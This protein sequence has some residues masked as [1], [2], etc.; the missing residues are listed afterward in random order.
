MQI[1]QQFQHQ[2]YAVFPQLLETQQ[3]NELVEICDRIKLQ[4]FHNKYGQAYKPRKKNISFFGDA[5]YFQL[6]SIES[7]CLAKIATDNRVLTILQRISKYKLLLND[8]EYFFNPS[9]ASW[10]GEWH[11][12]GQ[13]VADSDSIERSRIFNS[14]FIRVHIALMP[15]NFLEIMAGSHNRWDKL[16]E[17]VIRKGL[18]GRNPAEVMTEATKIHLEQGDAV[19][20]SGYS[21]HRASYFADVPRKML[22]LLYG[23]AVDWHMP[24][25]NILV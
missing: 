12:D 15:E 4:W 10:H 9:G 5:N 1:E 25:K 18:C 6:N 2:G 14:D 13:A 22:A 24:P 3:I 8:V 19:F 20:F 23:S 11:R 21:I 16:E 17:L 7:Q